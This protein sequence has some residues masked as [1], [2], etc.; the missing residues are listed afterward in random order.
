MNAASHAGPPPRAGTRHLPGDRDVWIFILAELLM[1]G[2]FFVAYIT[3]RHA[4]IALFNTSQA[5]LDRSLGALNTL[6]LISSSWLV[7]RAVAAVRSQH[8]RN[9]T[10]YLG[11][12]IVLALAFIVVKYFEYSAKF[13]AGMDLTT[14][15]FYMFYFTLTMIHLAHVVGGT[16]ILSVLWLNAREGKYH[17][18]NLRGL[19]AGAAYWHMVDLLWIFLFPLIYLLQ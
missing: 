13:A 6:F 16:V 7:V 2:T 9:A 14:N 17:S 1:F 8:G 18:R 19:E 3:N 12:A 11:G 15:D 10:H 4:E 5:T